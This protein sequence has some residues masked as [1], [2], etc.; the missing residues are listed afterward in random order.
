MSG[1]SPS[2]G[3]T[4]RGFLTA[5]VSAIVAGVVAGVGAYYAGTLSAPVKEVTKTLTTTTTLA[6]GA[7]I[8][9][10]VTETKTV[11]VSP[12]AAPVPKEP[13]KL[14]IITQMSGIFAPSGIAGL[15]AAQIW[16]DEVNAAGGILGRKVELYVEDESEGVEKSVERFKKLTLVTGC[17]AIFG[18]ESTATGL[19]FGKLAEEMGQLWLSWDGTT[20]QG[21]EETLPKAKYSFRSIYN[22]AEAVAGAI[23]TAKYFPDIKTIAGINDDYS[24]GRCCWEAYVTVLKHFKPEVQIVKELWTKAGETDFTSQIAALK[25]AKPDLI[26]S[27]YWAGH[28]T[29]F[30]QQAAAVGLFKDIKGA[31]V[32]AG[33]VLPTLKKDFVPEGLLI[34]CNSWYFEW[35]LG[36]PL[37]KRF[38]KEYLRRYNEYPVYECDH[39][40]FTL[41]AY[42]RA[43][44]LAYSLKGAWPTKEEI[45][46]QLRG[47]VVPSLSG[48]RGYREDGYQICNFYQGLSKHDPKYDFVRLDPVD[49]ISADLMCHPPEV[50]FHDWIKSWRA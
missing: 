11:T 6:P 21:L 30:L 22:E 35:P 24:Y 31:M 40:Y 50:R 27:S 16:A 9:T 19:A 28:A 32:T 8:T 33:G 2:K 5:A 7:P 36:W 10:T 18:T 47:I 13:L 20:Q 26:M 12:T 29:L 38:V 46:E 25:A 14:G 41:Q 42:K 17:E 43:V 34:G 23:L 1:T 49:V 44:E 39:A 48:Y 45:A 37:A 3:V 15:R 4:R